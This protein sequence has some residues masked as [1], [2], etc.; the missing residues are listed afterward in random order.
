MRPTRFLPSGRSTPVLP[1][2][3]ESIC[4]TRVV[5]TW[6]NRTPRRYVAAR[7]PAASPSAPPPMATSDIGSLDAQC[8]ELARRR[9]DDAEAFGGLAL[10]EHDPFNLRGRDRED[11]PRP[12]RPRQP[13]RP[14]RSRGSPVTCPSASSSV[15]SASPRI[16]SPMTTRP[17][18]VVARRSVVPLRARASGVG[19]RRSIE[20]TTPWI[21]ATPDCCT[22]A[23]A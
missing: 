22:C 19:R 1:P 2:I 8:R 6:M 10:R 21:S 18:G 15:A 12:A 20:S 11:P 14:V 4:A 16:P 9:L 23:A 7:K 13:T 5:G 17:I 3:D